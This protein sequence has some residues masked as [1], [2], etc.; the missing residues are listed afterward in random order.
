MFIDP[1][2]RAMVAARFEFV[3]TEVTPQVSRTP[4]RVEPLL[5]RPR[6]GSCSASCTTR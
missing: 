2:L 4:W 6:C 3:G 1:D 5:V